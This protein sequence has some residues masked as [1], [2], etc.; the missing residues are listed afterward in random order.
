MT[1]LWDHVNNVDTPLPD[2]PGGVIR[3]Y[4]ASAA[5]AMLPLTP[6]NNWTP[7]LLFCGG[8][9]MGDHDWG[10]YSGPN[11]DTWT[12]TASSDCR[13]LTPEPSDGSQPAYEQDDDMV[14]PRTMG[15]FILLPTG[16]LLLLNGGQKGTA[17]YAIGTP[18]TP[19][20]KMPFGRSLAAEPVLR[21]VIYDP[22]AAKG[23]RWSTQGLSASQIPRLYHSSAIL[24]PD[25]SVVVAGSNP[26]PDV[27]ISTYFNTEYR[28]DVFY[29][30]Y[31][32]ASVRPSPQ[33]LPRT[34]SYGGS[35]FDI[36]VPS[37]SYSGDGNAAADATIVTI[38]RSGFTTHA[39]NMGQRFM[40]L[41]NTYTVN[42]NGS[43]TLHVA[44]LPPNPNLFQP[45]P[46]LLYVCIQGI[47]STG[48]LVIVGNGLIGPQ[49][50]A[51]ASQL[52]AS[53]RFDGTV[54]G[55]SS[56]A[57]ASGTGTSSPSSTLLIAGIAGA[58][59]LLGLVVAIAGVCVARKKRAASEK[60]IYSMD[61]APP[62]G[63]AAGGVRG[64]HYSRASAAT[65]SSDFAPLANRGGLGTDEAWDSSTANLH[66]PYVPYRDDGLV[67]GSRP[68]FG[69][70][71]PYSGYSG[72]PQQHADSSL[73]IHMGM[74][75][76][77]SPYTTHSFDDLRSVPPSNQPQHQQE[78]HPSEPSYQQP[79]RD[80]RF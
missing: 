41:N 42:K 68:S 9:A 58:V 7:T 1:A 49:P 51:G 30:P 47:P 69:E 67:H 43:I 36:L 15:Q 22:A 60:P 71:D 28:A 4:P 13:R 6:D 59:V 23:S 72:V 37:S 21:P 12:V 32:S 48:K 62:L 19:D 54:T 38:V 26:N 24:L 46:A 78:Y 64:I 80:S 45:G 75:R 53:V 79:Y 74:N 66:A 20:S 39:M 16:K 3:V 40:Q 2:M 17:G 31:F 11:A 14:D 8:S 76:S 52:P 5:T 55:S 77:D 65:E 50:T 33:N 70:Y 44:Q 34:L 27:N 57:S 35:S 25:G 61:K 18:N 56:S 63:F 29:P 73:N 10:S